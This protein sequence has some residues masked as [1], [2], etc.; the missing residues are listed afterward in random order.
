[1]TTNN[2]HRVRNGLTL[3]ELLVT[4]TILSILASLAL[5][6]LF[7]ARTSGKIAKTSSTIRK[8]SEIIL[9]YYEQYESRRPVLP[10]TSTLSSRAALL[11]LRRT[12]LRRLMALELPERK[13]DVTDAFASAST[14]AVSPLAVTYGDV[15]LQLD[16]MPP[17]TRRYLSLIVGATGV[18]SADLLQ[19]IVM[20][21]PVAD[22][23]VIA[24]F[25]EDELADTNGNGIR[26]FVDA[27]GKPI[28][29]KRW[30]TG[31]NSPAQPIDG[32][33]SS[34][35]QQISAN[36]HRLVPL[37][38]SAGV[39]GSYDIEAGNNLH[40]KEPLRYDPFAA[41]AFDQA[42]IQAGAV[43]L[44]PVTRTGGS[45]V[46]Y[47][48]RRV[49]STGGYAGTTTLDPGCTLDGNSPLKAVGS[50]CDTGSSDGDQ[51]DGR[52]DSTDNIHNH[53]LTR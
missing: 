35:D 32:R 11:D 46:T 19:L 27:W 31:F 16:E 14:G 52:V 24:H 5:A 51:P 33:F 25:R 23:D 15:S 28:M 38:Y 43:V 41:G 2:R 13:T 47:L 50:E 44:F 17:T 20:R 39:D 37:I 8:L 34:S 53:D 40:Y 4:L 29:F 3:I 22:P 49:T 6:G 36:G 10:N 7:S 42:S 30:P 21:G 18:T 26:E 48:A 12:A 1:M 45:T 9:P